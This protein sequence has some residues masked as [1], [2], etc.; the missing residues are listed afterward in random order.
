[1]LIHVLS[2]N[3][4]LNDG[5]YALFLFIDENRLPIFISPIFHVNLEF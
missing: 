3:I 5:D 4:S 2:K 1:M